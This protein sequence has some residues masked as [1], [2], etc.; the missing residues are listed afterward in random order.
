MIGR[1]LLALALLS[2]CGKEIII[3]FILIKLICSL[4]LFGSDARAD[5]LLPERFPPEFST[6]DSGASTPWIAA[7]DG[8]SSPPPPADSKPC[9]RVCHKP[10][11]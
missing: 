2:N 8:A 5:A 4:S 3:V 9:H 11:R 6:K 10:V 7:K 1:G